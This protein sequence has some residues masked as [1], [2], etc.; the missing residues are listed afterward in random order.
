MRG[1]PVRH[2][3]GFEMQRN[4][5]HHWRAVGR[6]QGAR[7]YRFAA[8]GGGQRDIWCATISDTQ[9]WRAQFKCGADALGHCQRAIIGQS[10]EPQSAGQ[11]TMVRRSVPLAALSSKKL[12]AVL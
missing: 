8:S 3:R 5:L 11:S 10:L 4:G 9:Q 1:C 6:P 12:G 7:L 2:G